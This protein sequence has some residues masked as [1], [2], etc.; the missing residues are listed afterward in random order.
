MLLLLLVTGVNNSTLTPTD[1]NPP[2]S[3]APGVVRQNC[4]FFASLFSSLLAA[5]GAVLAKQWLADYERTGQTGPLEEKGLRRTEKFNGAE[6]WKLRYVVEALPTLILISLGFFFVAIVDFVWTINQEV[7]ILIAAFSAVG[8]ASWIAMLLSA[9][10]FSDCPYQSAPSSALAGFTRFVLRPTLL[11][12]RNALITLIRA[13]IQLWGKVFDC[14]C[15]GDSSSRNMFDVWADRITGLRTPTTRLW[16][17][18]KD[19]TRGQQH[20]DLLCASSAQLVLEISPQEDVTVAVSRNIPAIR[21]LQAVQYMAEGTAVLSLTAYLKR[22]FDCLGNKSTSS[23]EDNIVTVARAL[24]H[25]LS[26]NPNRYGT[27]VL[28]GLLAFPLEEI[29]GIQKW[30]PSAEL[31]ILWTSIIRLCAQVST[32]KVAGEAGTRGWNWIIDDI[33]FKGLLNLGFS[34]DEMV[35]PSTAELYLHHFILSELFTLPAAQVRDDRFFRKGE[36]LQDFVSTFHKILASDPIP[37]TMSFLNLAS[38]AL[39]VALEC[40]AE[41]ENHERPQ[42]PNWETRLKEAWSIRSG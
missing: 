38:R 34:S 41:S 6:R 42:I 24:I 4:F 19:A 28:E 29:L 10:I 17:P 18:R 23:N 5:A 3:P 13:F 8:T 35:S 9:A 2:F 22:E 33:P 7:A 1:L 15:L 37:S 12:A 26:A 11:V 14:I 36:L 39:S 32:L 25:I 21:D 16:T 31:K 20:T 27:H 40:Q 30:L